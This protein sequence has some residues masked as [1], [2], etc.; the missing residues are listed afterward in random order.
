MGWLYFLCVCHVILTVRAQSGRSLA[1][2]QR[3]S[4]VYA[5]SANGTT[6]YG[7]KRDLLKA[8][9]TG[10]DVRI[11]IP[12]WGPGGYL[13]SVQNT[14]T[15]RNNVCAQAIFHVSKASYDTFQEVPYFWFVNLCSTGHVHMA[16]YFIGNHVSAGI[17]GDYVDMQW[18]IRH[19]PDPV[20]SHT[21][22]GTVISGN[23][24][25]V[26]YAI[27][28]GADIRIVDRQLGYGVRMDNL[29]VSYDRTIAAGQSLW[30]VSERMNGPNLEFQGDD[31]WWFSV[32]STD[33]TVD[34]SRWNIGEHVKRGNSSMQQ[35][36]NWYADSCWQM[37]YK[38]DADGKLEDGSLELLRLAV[39]TG[40]RIKVLID[41][42][43]TVEPDQIN[44]RGGHINAEILSLA[45]KQDLKTFTDDVFWD[46]RVLATTG[47]ETSE[48]FNVGEYFNRGNTI[49]KK[50]MTW[51][52]DT[53]TWNRVLVNDKD[54][55]VL[56]GTKQK[57]I[58]AI[59][60]GAEVRY[61]LTFRSNAIMHQAD[62]L[63]IS[64]DGNVG[65]MHVRSVSLKFTPG[66]A[67]E[68]T[69]QNSPYWWFTIVSTTGKVDISRWT[70]GEHVNRRHTHLF[71]KVEWFVSY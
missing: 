14:Q 69:F 54:G 57:L 52:I 60:L 51:F 40:H 61:Q 38:H 20:Y 36:M 22:D 2:H 56:A 43:I 31:Y 58:D 66:S 64:A 41:G 8:T 71:V 65:A 34:I 49:K 28:A 11:F 21:Q 33:G 55:K 42:A 10:A 16:R 1:C 5:N 7:E 63:E 39:E 30:H 45:S 17:N 25:D 44:V 3:W 67:Y 47:T 19:Y 32:W 9:L 15:I 23:V 29:E 18:Y 35:S 62:N 37:A 4:L 13:T 53:R 12:S 48:Y 59:L 26:V 27:E 68:V 70:V 46:W 50:P 6:V 24:R